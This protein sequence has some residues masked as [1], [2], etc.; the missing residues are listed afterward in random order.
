MPWRR[1]LIETHLTR[2]QALSQLQEMTEP[3]KLIRFARP[4]RAHDFEGEITEAGF[5][6]QRIIRYRNSFRPVFV[7]RLDDSPAGTSINV[8]VRPSWLS[9]FALA[10]WIG[11]LIAA[12]LITGL[13]SPY[14]DVKNPL[15]LVVLFPA[16]LV[17]SIPFGL[18]VRWGRRLLVAAL[19]KSPY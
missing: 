18:E 4:R 11:S 10:V 7:G 2:A 9:A 3:R 1:F 16:Y 19:S 8:A 13:K 14:H 5:K 17:F 15:I 12:V 6:L